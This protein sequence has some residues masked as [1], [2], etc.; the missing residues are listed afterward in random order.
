[1]KKHIITLRP[2]PSKYFPVIAECIPLHYSNVYSSVA[3]ALG[4]LTGRFG[5]TITIR[6]ITGKEA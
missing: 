4:H 6:N 2:Y 5:S 3:E 1:M